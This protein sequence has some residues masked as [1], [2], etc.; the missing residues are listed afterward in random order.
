M[1]LGQAIAVLVVAL[2]LIGLSLSM[3]TV[4]ETE[5]AIVL[6]L[7]QPVGDV[8]HPGLHFKIPFVQDVR[9]FDSRILAVDPRPEQMVISSAVDSPL[10]DALVEQTVVPSEHVSISGEP[11][12]VDTFSRY[13]ITDPLKFMKTLRTVEAANQRL[14][15][16]INASTRTILGRTTLRQLLSEERNGVMENITKRVNGQIEADQLGIQII[17]VRIVRADLTPELRA[18]TVR[19]MISEL[20]ERA[21]ETRAK[22]EERALEIRSTAEKERSVLLAEAERSAQIMKG[23][24]DKEAIK[25]Y[26][27]A[28]NKDK[29]FYGFMRSL[30]AYRKTMANPDTRLILSPDSEFFQYF[31]SVHSE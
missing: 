30:E 12:I 10:R 21:T 26:S 31:K 25:V 16:I 4:D 27:A 17:D 3:F 18:S 9:R 2:G 22:G 20:K 28:F 7:G 6:Q 14:E 15:S 13:R 23:E 5:Q 1:K 8:K 29:D 19:R 24:G 11:I